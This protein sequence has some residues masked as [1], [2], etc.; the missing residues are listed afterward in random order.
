ME[1]AYLYSKPRAEFGRDVRACLGEGAPALLAH[2]PALAPE[3]AAA[4]M[5]RQYVKRNPCTAEVDNTP[6]MY[7]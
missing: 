3:E 1:A 7:V 6:R 2:V 5:A 4:L